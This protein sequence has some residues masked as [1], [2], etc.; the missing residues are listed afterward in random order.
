MRA[1]LGAAALML[2]MA[3]TAAAQ[4]F[5]PPTGPVTF[6]GTQASPA[7]DSFTL[8]FDG[9]APEALTM[10]GSIP[11]ACPVGTTHAFEIP[12]NRFTVGQH[13]VQVRSTNA[14]G[15]TDGATITV[16]VGVA[17][18]PFTITGVIPPA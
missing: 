17:P 10:L 1:I 3:T 14:F 18:G 6:C 8:V 5:P 13:T 12:A 4:Q 16:T 2:L 7:A 9:N 11:A 15:T